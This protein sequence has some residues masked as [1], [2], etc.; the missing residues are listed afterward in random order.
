MA[1][2]VTVDSQA[3]SSSGKIVEELYHIYATQTSADDGIW[4][5]TLGWENI[6][7]VLALTSATLSVGGSNADVAPANSADGTELIADKTASDIFSIRY[8]DLPKWIKFHASTVSTNLT[9]D[10]RVRKLQYNS[11]T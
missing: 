6:N 1:A 8:Y 11:I 2:S 9:L 4:Q 7:C 3:I 5:N 10:I